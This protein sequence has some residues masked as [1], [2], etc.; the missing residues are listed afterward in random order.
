LTLIRCFP[1]E[2]DTFNSKEKAPV[3]EFSVFTDIPINNAEGTGT[4]FTVNTEDA[5]KIERLEVRR[6]FG[7]QSDEIRVI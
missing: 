2:L 6:Y 5:E 3:W 1:A 7:E 4:Y